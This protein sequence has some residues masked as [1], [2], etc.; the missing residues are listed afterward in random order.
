M[1]EYAQPGSFGTGGGGVSAP[2]EILTDHRFIAAMAID[3]PDGYSLSL[4]H[5]DGWAIV[6]DCPKRSTR[7]FEIVGRVIHR[8]G[9][10]ASA[11]ALG[12][13]GPVRVVTRTLL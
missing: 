6:V 4:E 11:T 13:C 1:R 10:L 7:A 12:L 9:G 3:L 5:H 2:D 8:L